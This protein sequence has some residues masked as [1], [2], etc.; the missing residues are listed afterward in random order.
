VTTGDRSH[1]FHGPEIN[2]PTSNIYIYTWRGWDFKELA[3]VMVRAGK[4]KIYRAGYQAGNSCTG[5]DAA[6]LR[7]NFFFPI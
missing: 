7:Q 4:S 5:A 1:L 6:V 2:L 3:Y